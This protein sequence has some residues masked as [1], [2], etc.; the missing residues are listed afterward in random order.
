MEKIKR[1]LPL[2]LVIVL[3]FFAIAPLLHPGFF[4][5][6]DDTQ[7]QRVFEM[8]KSLKSGMFPVRWVQDLGFGYGYPI[9]NFYAPLA[10]YAGSFF[11]LLGFDP[12]FSAK[13]MMAL[14]ILLSGVFMYLLADELFGKLAGIVSALFYVYAPYHAVDIYVR[15]D[16]AEF[17]AYAFIPL[18]FYGVLK[19]F[20]E[21]NFKGVATAALGF[22]GI[23]LSHNLTAMMV[24]PF[25]FVFVWILAFVPFKREKKTYL[26]LFAGLILGVLVS[27]FYWLP[28]LSEMKYSNVLS[29]VGGY[30]NNFVC[31]TQL[32]TS[33]WGFGGSVPGCVDG[34]SFMI[35]KSQILIS[36]IA[37]ILA[38]TVYFYKKKKE[39]RKWLL[40][41]LVSFFGLAFSAFLTLSYS[42]FIW[43]NIPLM[44]YFQFP[45]RFLL[46]V[47]FFCA[48]LAG[49][50]VKLLE[51]LPVKKYPKHFKFGVAS[52]LILTLILVSTKYFFTSPTSHN[53]SIEYAGIYGSNPSLYTSDYAVKW[54]VS[55][56]TYEYMPPGFF[57]PQ[58]PDQVSDGKV[59]TVYG[60]ALVDYLKIDPQNYDFTTYS[61]SNVA[62][63]IPIAYFPFWNIKVDGQK[64]GFS[65]VQ[66][67]ILINLAAGNHTVT[68]S[69][70]QT[71]IEKTADLVSIAGMLLLVTGIIH[72]KRHR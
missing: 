60:S 32:W 55:R 59:K 19:T 14:G 27:C 26:Y 21:K 64:T 48:I 46:M 20:R 13:A 23:I 66:K 29:Q 41:A 28:A 25:L 10:Y 51:Y 47:L 18:A 36:L 71:P 35:G 2:V 65:S 61:D 53:G 9:F 62:I 58:N 70:D 6:H 7:V 43:Q 45:W 40:I 17:W 57:V 33:P 50:F 52:L 38:I 3:S 24:F 69:Y 31:L 54:L 49:L 5:V 12:L 15:G 4:P 1:F 68:L 72:K 30:Q 16:V 63:L 8:T 39:T 56:L 22:A 34:M 37:L 67:G 42:D 44:N 11:N